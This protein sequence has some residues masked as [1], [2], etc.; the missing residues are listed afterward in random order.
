MVSTHL[1]NISQNGNLPQVISSE[2]KTYLK[3][4]RRDTHVLLESCGATPNSPDSLDDPGLQVPFFL[5][6]D[7]RRFSRLANVPEDLAFLKLRRE[8]NG[9]RYTPVKLKQPR[10]W[11]RIEDN[12]PIKNEDILVADS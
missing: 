7:S 11:T 3:A 6:R 1:K 2:N 5:S 4:P 12:F 8:A 9:G 10:E